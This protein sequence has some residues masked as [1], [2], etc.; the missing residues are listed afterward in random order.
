MSLDIGS[1]TN[2]MID[3]VRAA[4]GDRW[5]A[6]HAVA[7]PELRKLAQTLEDT[8]QQYAEGKITADRAIQLVSMQRNLALSVVLA[9]EGLGVATAR[10]A[11]NAAARAAGKVVNRLVGFN[12][13]ESSPSS[14]VKAKFKAGKDI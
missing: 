8:R 12:L 5:P 10:E 4:I 14:H 1:I 2:T 11:I 9:V 7:E 13:I 3:G 6:I